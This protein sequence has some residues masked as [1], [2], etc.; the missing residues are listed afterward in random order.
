MAN[1]MVTW[2][3]VRDKLSRSRTVY[4]GLSLSKQAYKFPLR[5]AAR[6]AFFLLGKPFFQL[7]AC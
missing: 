4:F 3:S 7:L 5:Y 2:K 1:V 6:M